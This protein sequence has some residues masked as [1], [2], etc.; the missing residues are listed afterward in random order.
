MNCMSARKSK[1][2]YKFGLTVE[3]YDKMFE[4]Q[5]GLCA[6]CGKCETRNAPSGAIKRLSIDHDHRTGYVRK[7]LCYQCNLTLGQCKEDINILANAIKYL[8]EFKET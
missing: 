6:I 1:L 5:N 2:K 3:Q 4:Q 7:L 8:S